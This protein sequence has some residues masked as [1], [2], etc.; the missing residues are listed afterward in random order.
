[1]ISDFNKQT[2]DL[3]RTKIANALNEVETETG[4]KFAI[5][6]MRYSTDTVKMAITANL[7][8][9]PV[10]PSKI[11]E[12]KDSFDYVC[13]AYG[14]KP[15]HRGQRFDIQG[16]TYELTG[17]KTRSPKKPILITDVQT[18]KNFVATTSVVLY[19]LGLPPGRVSY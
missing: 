1:M 9:A 3:L 19:A 10:R 13:Q 18:G 7:A 11:D 17:I 4:V 15:E 6:T 14:M 2:L 12:A 16:K 8:N 5:G